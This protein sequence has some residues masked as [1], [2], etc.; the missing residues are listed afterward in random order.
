MQYI[1]L[2]EAKEQLAALIDTVANGEQVFITTD[3]QTVVQLV[4]AALPQHAPTFGSA[5]GL[6][7]VPDDFD[8]PLPEFEPYMR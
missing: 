2:N 6:I 1:T 5:R 3:D 8:D 7:T 4:L